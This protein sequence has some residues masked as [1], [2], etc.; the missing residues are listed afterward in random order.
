MKRTLFDEQGNPVTV[1]T[2]GKGED[3]QDEDLTVEVNTHLSGVAESLKGAKKVH[4]ITRGDEGFPWRSLIWAA[5]I[6]AIVALIIL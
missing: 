2:I 4:V 5:A 6:V 3:W 1:I